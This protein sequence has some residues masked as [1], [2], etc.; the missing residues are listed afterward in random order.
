MQCR[1]VGIERPLDLTPF[2]SRNDLDE[3]GHDDPRPQRPPQRIEEVG[4]QSKRLGRR[5]RFECVASDIDGEAE[6]EADCEALEHNAWPGNGLPQLRYVLAYPGQLRVTE[7]VWSALCPSGSGICGHG[8]PSSWAVQLRG[9]TR[10]RRTRRTRRPSTAGA[11]A[12]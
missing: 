5:R 2:G 12:G 3:Q 6:H 10:T 1:L 4:Q 9:I 11:A 8:R 7:G